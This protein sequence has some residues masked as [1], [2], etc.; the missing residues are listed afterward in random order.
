M[1][2]VK[3]QLAGLIAKRREIMECNHLSSLLENSLVLL[4]RKKTM[5]VN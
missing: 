4:E 3:R 2:E 5:K 1:K